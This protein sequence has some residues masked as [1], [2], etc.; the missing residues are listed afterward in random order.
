MI[1]IYMEGERRGT[2]TYE[3][4]ESC[5]SLSVKVSKSLEHERDASAA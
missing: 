4:R 5:S 1:I 3:S 2:R